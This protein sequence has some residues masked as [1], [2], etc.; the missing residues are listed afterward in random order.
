MDDLELDIEVSKWTVQTILSVRVNG[1]RILEGESRRCRSVQVN[2]KK[3][4]TIFGRK[5]LLRQN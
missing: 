2:D 3:N 5:I 4:N 1:S